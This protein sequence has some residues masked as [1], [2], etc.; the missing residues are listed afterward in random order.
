MSIEII[1]LLESQRRAFNSRSTLL[2]VRLLRLQNRIDLAGRI[3][4]EV[5]T[6]AGCFFFAAAR[7]ARVAMV[8]PFR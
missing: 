3:D 1:T 5:S 8:A 6:A 2:N 4:S 7:V